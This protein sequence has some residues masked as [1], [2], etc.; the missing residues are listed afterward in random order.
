MNVNFLENQLEEIREILDYNYSSVKN[1]GTVAGLSGISLFYFYYSRYT[2]SDKYFNEG[3]KILKECIGLIN[4]GYNIS[5]YANGI[6][7]LGWLLNHLEQEKFIETNSKI[8]PSELE[9]KLRIIM[10]EDLKSYN[11]DF[12]Y[13]AVGYALYFLSSYENTENL[14]QKNIYRDILIQFLEVLLSVGEKD[15]N[16]IKWLSIIDFNNGKKGY[17]LGLSHGVSSIIAILAKLHQ[18]SD[19]K[20]ITEPILEKTISYL[21]SFKSKDELSYSLFPNSISLHGEI[22]NKSRLAWCYGDLGVGLTL[23]NASRVLD[24]EELKSISLDVLKHSAKRTTPNQTLVSEPT[25]CHG[26]FG[27]YI[28]FNFLYSKTKYDI[29]KK[30]S[31]YWFKLGIGMLNPKH[32]T[33]IKHD[34]WKN[35]SNTWKKDFSLISGCSGI[36]L[37]LINY[38]ADFDT[39]WDECILIR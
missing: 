33:I 25:I 32:S 31:D 9:D 18:H 37:A 36:G 2:N 21:I 7:G 6:S 26:S 22:V 8:F 19:F 15:N 14:K 17:N 39:N 34:K 23:F 4:Q 3:S 5:T 30:S 24:N 28:I 16:N 27:N 12:L 11:Y 35:T 10:L 38:L 20:K 13:G 29:F 1:I